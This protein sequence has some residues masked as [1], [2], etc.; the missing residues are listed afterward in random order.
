VSQF[1]LS[2]THIDAMVTAALQWSASEG[3]AYPWGGAL[4]RVTT[5]NASEVG[6][7]LWDAHL[8]SVSDG[9]PAVLAD[10]TGGRE[11]PAYV[12]DALPGRADPWVV[13]RVSACFT[14][15]TCGDP[16]LWYGSEHAVVTERL[17]TWATMLL[18]RERGW[19][20]F[21]AETDRYAFYTWGTLE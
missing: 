18:A 13:L 21:V 3:F 6:A 11:L 9:D 5:D 7:L 8:Q 4:H 20:P 2:S 16:D 12:F 10:L 15:Q 14:Y 19:P 17:G 1:L